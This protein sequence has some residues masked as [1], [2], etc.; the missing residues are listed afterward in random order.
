MKVSSLPL[1]VCGLA[2]LV[3]ASPTE[4]AAQG[5]PQ[6]PPKTT[7]IDFQKEIVPIVKAHCIGCHNKDK[8]EHKIEFPDKMTEEEAIKNPRLWRPS[9][10]EVKNNKM[11]PKDSSNMSDTERKKFV[12]WVEAKVPRPARRPGTTGGNHF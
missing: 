9:A 12:E 6:D 3:I 10:R 1:I 8:A 2:V 5:G 7:K 4:G 11:P